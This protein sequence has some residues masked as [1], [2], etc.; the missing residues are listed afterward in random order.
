MAKSSL[1]NVSDGSFYLFN[2]VVSSAA[3]GFIAYILVFREP[4]P[5]GVDLRFLPAVNATLNGIATLLLM[6]AWVAIRRREVH[7]HKRLMVAAFAASA[8]FLVCYLTYHWAHG[9]TRYQGE[10]ILRTLYFSILIPHI[11]LS[12]VVVPGALAA[13]F[14][15]YRREFT[16]HKR[17]TRILMPIWLY[18]SVTGVII[19]FMLRS[20]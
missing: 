10:G 3:L 16:R 7:L 14:F 11:V 15:A 4:G 6:A 18:V 12:A 2:A 1:A 13:F 9:D 5:A 20:S 19:F 17:V 8:L